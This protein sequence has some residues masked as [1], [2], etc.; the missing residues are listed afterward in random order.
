MEDCVICMEARLSKECVNCNICHSAVCHT[1]LLKMKSIQELYLR[2][3]P[4]CRGTNCL[5]YHN[6]KI[7][8]YY[9]ISEFRVP[10]IHPDHRHLHMIV[11]LPRII[12]S[13]TLL[14]VWIYCILCFLLRNSIN[15]PLFSICLVCLAHFYCN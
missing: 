11:T 7:A 14:F 5:R 15:I 3:C 9:D 8:L 10:R 6:G 12:L 13:W 2:R 4:T 1:C